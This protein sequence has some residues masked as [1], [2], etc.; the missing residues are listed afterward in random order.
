M[1]PLQQRGPGPEHKEQGRR[2]GQPGQ[3]P[4]LVIPP[5]AARN[6]CERASDLPL[7]EGEDQPSQGFHSLFQ[8]VM[9]THSTG[10]LPNPGTEPSEP[11]GNLLHVYTYFKSIFLK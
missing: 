11:P 1:E 9:Q 7:C 3:D 8:H 10:D 4:C 6:P 2:P 5:E